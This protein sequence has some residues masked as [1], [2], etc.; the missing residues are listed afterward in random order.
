MKKPND[1]DIKKDVWKP[2]LFIFNFSDYTT[3]RCCCWSII[4][5]N[6]LMSNKI[7]QH[8]GPRKEQRTYRW[9]LIAIYDRGGTERLPLNIFNRSCSA[10]NLIWICVACNFCGR[11]TIGSHIIMIMMADCHIPVKTFYPLTMITY[12]YSK[13]ST[14]S[15]IKYG[16]LLQLWPF[17][18]PDKLF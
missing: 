3:E 5:G 15:N 7:R 10:E 17:T 14:W 2:R 1:K 13:K 12:F 11:R 4:T 16:F 9:Y 18:R 8:N 6:K